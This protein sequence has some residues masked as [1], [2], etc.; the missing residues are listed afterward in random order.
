METYVK[1]LVYGIIVTSGLLFTYFHMIFW[2]DLVAKHS[3]YIVSLGI[4]PS[5][6]G[7]LLGCFGG[8][9]LEKGIYNGI[10]KNWKIKAIGM[11][12]CLAPV[13]YYIGLMTL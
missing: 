5:V 9:V 10:I 7:L 3:N 6:T 12:A 1:R 13:V 2:A 11:L 8:M 4:V